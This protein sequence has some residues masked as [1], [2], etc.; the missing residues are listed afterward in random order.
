VAL[1]SKLEEVQRR[2]GNRARALVLVVES[3]QQLGDSPGQGTFSLAWLPRGDAVKARSAMWRS[4]DTL[5]IFAIARSFWVER[6][7]KRAPHCQWFEC[8]LGAWG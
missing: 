4:N 8:G 2:M 3:S 5:V 6:K 1:A 7:I